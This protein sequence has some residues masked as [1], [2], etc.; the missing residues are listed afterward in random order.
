M[1]AI[2]NRVERGTF[3]C[4]HHNFPFDHPVCGLCAAPPKQTSSTH[5]KHISYNMNNEP[6]TLFSL[7]LFLPQLHIRMCLRARHFQFYARPFDAK[8]IFKH[9]RPQTNPPLLAQPN[10]KHM[11]SAHGP[12]RCQMVLIL[13]R[14]HF[15]RAA[16]AAARHRLIYWHRPAGPQVMHTHTHTASSTCTCNSHCA[17]RMHACTSRTH[18]RAHACSDRIVYGRARIVRAHS[19][20]ARHLHTVP[21]IHAH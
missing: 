14:S 4:C 12:I 5:P 11:S 20:R 13:D 1:A 18:A 10:S 3:L 16:A 17:A 6:H 7:S 9:C 19:K 8:L 21:Y 15:S 2:S